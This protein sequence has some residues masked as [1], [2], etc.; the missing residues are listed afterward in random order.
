MPGGRCQKTDHGAVETTRKI[1]NRQ[2][3]SWA[4]RIDEVHFRYDKGSQEVLRGLDLDIYDNEILMINGSNGCGKSTLLSLIAGV[5]KPY[6]GRIKI[7]QGKSV[8]MLPQ[9]PELLF[10]RRSVREELVDAS[11]RKKLVDIV[12]FCK[13]EHLMD[14]HPYDLSGGEKQRLAL[15]K[16]TSV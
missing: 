11:D 5:N 7:K 4:V 6:R 3:K 14:R 15:A 8:G 12:R 10:T 2:D 16:G 9:N 13:L 1:A